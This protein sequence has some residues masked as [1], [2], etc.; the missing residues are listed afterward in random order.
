MRIDALHARHVLIEDQF[1]PGHDLAL[2]RPRSTRSSPW[3]GADPPLEGLVLHVP[4]SAYL[5]PGVVDTHVH[6]NEPGRT[7]WEGFLSAT[8]A[9][10]LGGATTLVDMP[11]NS[12]PPTT[13]VEAL[14]VKQGCRPRRADGRRR[15]LGWCDP[16]E[17]RRS[18]TAVGRRGL[19]LQVLLVAIGGW[20]SSHPSTRTS[21]PPPLTE[22][23]RF[24]AV[25]DRA[26]RG[27]RRAGGGARDPE[28]GVPRLRLVPTGRLGGGGDPAGAGRG[29]ADGGRGCTSCTC[30]APRPWT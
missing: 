17:S 13:T 10:A 1:R 29:P 15:V 3:G 24:A 23:A 14:R 25:D 26:R 9:A 11:L 18:G 28:S 5:V 21:S 7:D 22:V 19:R 16:G 8:E 4:D 12:I 27:R 30:P 2:P 20:M 6:I